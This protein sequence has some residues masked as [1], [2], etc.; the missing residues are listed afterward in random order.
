LA[1]TS[2]QMCQALVD[3]IEAI[4]LSAKYSAHPGDVFRGRI[5]D[6]PG[7]GV[8]RAFGVIPLSASARLNRESCEGQHT[9]QVEIVI[10]Y[11]ATE[12]AI[13]RIADDGE[14]VTEALEGLRG[15]DSDVLDLQIPP[16]DAISPGVADGTLEATRTIVVE[17]R[18]A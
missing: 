16:G 14:L 17:W 13:A 4:D 2:S 12:D 15:T 9:T 6:P 11:A 18:R 8:D 1:K 3:A 7:T 5:G 10:E